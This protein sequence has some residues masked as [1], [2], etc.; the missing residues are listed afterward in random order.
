MS[1]HL[2][3]S[4]LAKESGLERRDVI[5]KCV[6]WGVPIFNGKI[7]K[8]LFNSTLQELAKAGPAQTVSV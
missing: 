6:A 5:A 3:P 8:T 7:D 2:T 1:N 4:E